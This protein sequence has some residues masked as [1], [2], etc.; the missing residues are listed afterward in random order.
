MRRT[1]ILL[2]QCHFLAKIARSILQCLRVTYIRAC[3]RYL[4]TDT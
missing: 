4:D 1:C 3:P 2:L